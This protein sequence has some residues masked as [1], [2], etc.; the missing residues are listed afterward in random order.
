MH[1]TI[2]AFQGMCTWHSKY[3]GGREGGG[4]GGV[5]VLVDSALHEV[6][7]DIIL[8]SPLGQLAHEDPW[9][10]G[11]LSHPVRAAPG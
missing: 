5:G 7:L 3:F 1:L 11:C 8:N 10:L 6:L 4:G 9:P 2:H